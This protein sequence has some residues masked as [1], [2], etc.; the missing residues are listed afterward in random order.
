MIATLYKEIGLISRDTTNP[1][2]KP[3]CK[4]LPKDFSERA[5]RKLDKG[6]LSL[7]FDIF[8]DKALLST[9][10]KYLIYQWILLYLFWQVLQRIY[11]KVARKMSQTHYEH[12]NTVNQAVATLE[13]LEWLIKHTVSKEELPAIRQLNKN[14]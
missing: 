10:Y 5:N 14:M 12:T 11:L 8:F 1:N 3:G 13:C 7:E 9:K 4:F 6:E 2:Y